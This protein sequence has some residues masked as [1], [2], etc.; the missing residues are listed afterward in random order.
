MK[1]YILSPHIDDAA[2]GLTLTIS[3]LISN[4]V[5]VNLIN[6]FTI[7][8]WTG[9]FVSKDIEV[10]SALRKEEDKAFNQYL[11][12]AIQVTNLELLDAPLRNSYIHLFHPFNENELELIGQ[13]KNYTLENVDGLLLC[14]LALGNHIDH[15]LCLEAVI[16]VYPKIKIVF[17]E[18]LPY[19]NRI[20]FD[21]IKS[22]VNNLA[23]RLDK[24]LDSF[25]SDLDKCTIDKNHA[26]HLYKSQV[27]EEICAEIIA[28]QN[29][30]NG[31]RLWGETNNIDLLKA[32]LN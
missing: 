29:A 4:H 30:L 7:T 13:L 18:D 22:H 28:H 15:I 8:K 20:S 14:P 11:G 6:C 27:D 24:K 5:S 9:V 1:T 31:E 26:I 10:V 32:L 12:S 23:K 19:A 25:I 2:F 3:K 16:Q 17:F 21:E